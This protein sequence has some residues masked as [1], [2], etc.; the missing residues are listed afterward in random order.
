[1]PVDVAAAHVRAEGTR[2]LVVTTASLDT[3]KHSN[4]RAGPLKAAIRV[5]MRRLLSAKD[6]GYG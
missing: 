5:S 1:M 2:W 6:S 4:T 3:A